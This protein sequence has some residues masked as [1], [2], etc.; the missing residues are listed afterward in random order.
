MVAILFFAEIAFT[1][2]DKGYPSLTF[3]EEIPFSLKLENYYSDYPSTRIIDESVTAFLK[4]Y[5]IKG[6]SVAVTRDEKLVYAKGFGYSNAE[7]SEMVK[8]GHLFRLAS[9]SKLITAVAIMKLQ[10]EGKLD[11]DEKVFGPDGILN[12]PEFRGY[13]DKRYEKIEIRHLLNHTSGWSKKNG[14]PIFNSLYIARVLK[15]NPPATFDQILAYSLKN[16]LSWDPGKK[17]A[18]SNLGYAILGKIIEIKSGMPYQDYVTMHI[19]KPVGIHDMHIGHSFYHQKYQ[20]E[21]KYYQDGITDRTFSIDGSGELVPIYYGGN[22]IELLGA[23]G[24]WV[25]S[26]PELAKFLTAVDAFNIQPDILEPEDLEMM[27]NPELSGKG[28]FGWRGSDFSGTWW[29]T[30]YLAGSVAMVVRQHDGTNWVILLNTT[31]SRQ[32]H[33]HRYISSMMFRAVNSVNEWPEIDLFSP[34]KNLHDDLSL[35]LHNNAKLL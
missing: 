15:V 3:N 11:L 21:V 9:V 31:T 16:R 22:N 34:E 28:L 27:T 25:S 5:R 14:D 20:N 12:D 35:M 1:F 29:R 17:Y 33:I 7:N 2:S 13:S 10:E 23:A 8:P 24:G 30:G 26:A 4:K 19:L 18:Y 32:S 6:A